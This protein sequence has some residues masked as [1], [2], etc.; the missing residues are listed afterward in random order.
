MLDGEFVGR[1]NLE[2]NLDGEVFTVFDAVER[3]EMIVDSFKVAAQLD[4]LG[5]AHQQRVWKGQVGTGQDRGLAGGSQQQLLGLG[6]G[7]RVG[8]QV[9]ALL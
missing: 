1:R 5:V 2:L 4:H 3:L 8:D 6:I 9:L 7:L